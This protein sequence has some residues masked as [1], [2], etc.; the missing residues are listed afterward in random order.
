M[1]KPAKR[2]KGKGIYQ[3]RILLLRCHS[4]VHDMV[5]AGY[6]LPAIANLI[7]D[8]MQE[9]L[10]LDK[11]VLVV[12]LWRYRQS[13]KE[14]GTLV[15]AALPRVFWEAK[16]TFSNKMQELERLE[17]TIM[18]LQYRIDLAHAAERISN[19]I[20][21][22]V[23]RMVRE[24]TNV[25]ARMHDIKMDLGLV[26]SRDLGTITVSAERLEAVRLKYGEKAAS[27]YADPVSRNRVLAAINAIRK[28]SGDKT[29]KR[30]SAAMGM[31]DS[32]SPVID[33]DFS[34]KGADAE[35]AAAL[36]AEAKSVAKPVAKPAKSVAKKVAK[37]KKKA[38]EKEAPREAL[39]DGLTPMKKKE[40]PAPVSA[41]P[42][43]PEKPKIKR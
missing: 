4:V 42:P 1:G 32:D 27:A 34:A 11:Q 15:E 29:T 26:S 18:I 38:V 12:N 2:V 9:C 41:H 5:C 40:P 3:D 20:D 24:F 25:V 43:G 36:S 30:L 21:P 6:P 19:A 22:A 31:S 10:E 13:L 14:G 8:K 17:E 16:K 35:V 37:K 39:P 23:D 33:A 7:Q 28:V